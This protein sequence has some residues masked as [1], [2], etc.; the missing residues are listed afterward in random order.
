MTVAGVSC[1]AQASSPADSSP[2]SFEL[3]QQ[4][5][6]RVAQLPGPQ[7][8][9]APAQAAEAAEGPAKRLAELEQLRR[10][11]T[12]GDPPRHGSQLSD[13]DRLGGS[14]GMARGQLRICGDTAAGGRGR[15][16]GAQQHQ[17]GDQRQCCD[18]QRP[19]VGGVERARV[20]RRR[21]G[22]DTGA[23]QNH[24]KDRGA[25]RAT[26]ALQRIDLRGR[27][28][29]LLG[30]HRPEG[31]G[32]RRH[33]AQP[34][35]QA[36]HHEHQRERDDRGVRADEC[37]RDRAEAQHRHPPERHAA[38]PPETLGQTAGER[39]RDQRPDPLGAGEQAKSM[40]LSPR[41]TW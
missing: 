1:A 31:G 28:G 2:R 41:T 4:L 39:H 34:D 16:L 5:A 21:G 24:C 23:L 38:A 7:V 3:E 36:A 40:M 22:V 32:H 10:P 25:D 17:A 30:A 11:L 37:Q 18:P 9:V 19:P 35:R 12:L 13:P 33:E 27:V 20:L 29:D 6:L 14:L 8:G 26:G 15:T